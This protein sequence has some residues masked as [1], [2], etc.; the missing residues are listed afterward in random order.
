MVA[1]KEIKIFKFVHP[2]SGDV[3]TYADKKHSYTLNG[4]LLA[5]TTTPIKT[6]NEPS[7]DDDGTMITES[8]IINLWTA[9]KIT[10]SVREDLLAL[11]ESGEELNKTKIEEIIKKSK[12]RPKDVFKDAGLTGTEIHAL[13]EELIKDTILNYNGVILTG[14]SP[15]PQV[16]NFIQWAIK[17]KVKFLFSEEPIYS[18]DWFNGG[19]VDFICEIDGKILIGDIKTNGD[20]R[21]YYYN[22]KTFSYDKTRPQSNIKNKALIQVGAYG[23]MATDPEARKLI[24]KFDG[25]VIVNIMKSGEFVEEL[26]V[27]FN[28]NTERLIKMFDRIIRNYYDGNELQVKG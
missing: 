5:G 26:D 17:N 3:F 14:K 28:Y 15:F 12:A 18:K 19:T 1:K 16:D 27:R 20:K 6:Y 23:K 2:I 7:W 4:K 21:R 22:K 11:I 24:D 8:D 13:I 9:K 25:I 10:E